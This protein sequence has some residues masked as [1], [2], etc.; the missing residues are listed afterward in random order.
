MGGG[1]ITPQRQPSQVLPV[2]LRCRF[3][4]TAADA[5]HRRIRRSG[6]SN[7]GWLDCGVRMHA[8]SFV[9]LHWSNTVRAADERVDFSH[10]N[11][12]RYLRIPRNGF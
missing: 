1:S 2:K 11:I 6:P 5:S 9:L 8:R 3:E 10:E 7:N 4:M 12:G